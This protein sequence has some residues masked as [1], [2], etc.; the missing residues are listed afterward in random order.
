MSRVYNVNDF[1]F[2]LQK[3]IGSSSPMILVINKIDSAPSARTKW[4][5]SDC[6]S[7]TKYIFTCAITGEGIHDLESAISEI[8]GLNKIPAGGRRWSVNQVSYLFVCM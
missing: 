1:F 2:E 4:V 8:V 7:F 6:N 5:D 3:S